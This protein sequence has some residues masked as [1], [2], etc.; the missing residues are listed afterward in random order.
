MSLIKASVLLAISLIV[1]SC[2]IFEP[3]TIKSIYRDVNITIKVSGGTP[4]DPGNIEITS[5]I[6]DTIRIHATHIDVCTF[7]NYT[8]EGMRYSTDIE[9]WIRGEVSAGCDLYVP[10]LTILPKE[11]STISILPILPVDK[12]TM[13]MFYYVDSSLV[14]EPYTEVELDFEIK[15]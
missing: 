3:E 5:T 8:I 13:H 15:D 12:Y 11:T 4:Q 2:G 7:A 14:Y 1:F 10:P 9:K 6:D